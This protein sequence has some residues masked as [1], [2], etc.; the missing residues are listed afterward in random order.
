M[1]VIAWEQTTSSQEFQTCTT[2]K[3]FIES[4]TNI[5]TLTQLRLEHSLIF[6]LSP[7][8]LPE[9][10]SNKELIFPPESTTIKDASLIM[11]REK[12]AKYTLVR[13]REKTHKNLFTQL[14]Y[15]PN[16]SNHIGS[17]SNGKLRRLLR[18]RLG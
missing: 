11:V 15:L 6:E 12:N 9:V 2:S 14:C 3:G 16:F 10:T 7:D 17:S 5:S 18:T 1:S 13:V 4:A 8:N